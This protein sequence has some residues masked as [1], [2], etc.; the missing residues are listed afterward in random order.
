MRT[1]GGFI[2]GVLTIFYI[3]AQNA[4]SLPSATFCRVCDTHDSDARDDCSQTTGIQSKICTG[5]CIT[6]FTMTSSGLRTQKE[7]TDDATCVSE[8]WLS[9]S[10]RPECQRDNLDRL[11]VGEK[12]SVCCHASR[13]GNIRCS[14]DVYPPA[15]TLV[16]FPEIPRPTLYTP[17]YG[18]KLYQSREKIATSNTSTSQDNV[19]EKETTDTPGGVQIIDVKSDNDTN[20]EFRE[21]M[22]CA[23]CDIDQDHPSCGAST[24]CHG[25]RPLCMTSFYSDGMNNLTQVKRCAAVSECWS[26]WY[27][28]TRLRPDCMGDANND[29]YSWPGTKSG[30][31]HYCCHTPEGESSDWCNKAMWP[32]KPRN[33]VDM[34][35]YQKKLQQIEEKLT[36]DQVAREN[37]TDAQTTE[38]MVIENV[39]KAHPTVQVVTENVTKAVTTEEVV[40][41][42]VTNAQTTEKVGTE[43]ITMAKTTEEVVTEYVKQ[44][45]ITKQA[46]TENATTTYPTEKPELPEYHVPMVCGDCENID[47]GNHSSC[48]QS[49]LCFGSR[50]LCMTSFYSDG[51]MNLRQVK[52]CA[53][54]SECWS[55]W[56]NETRLRPDCM[57]DANNDPYSWPGTK[58]G[59]CH[60]CCHT[61]EG[62]SS[63]WCNKAMW[64]TKPRNLLD[65]PEYEANMPFRE[66]DSKENHTIQETTIDLV[67]TQQVTGVTS[68]I[69]SNFVKFEIIEKFREPMVC[70]ACDIDQDHP[71]CGASTEC[72][73]ARPLCMTS[74]YSDGRNNLTQVK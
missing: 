43:N 31:C 24:E 7:C 47:Q 29:P 54:V 64:P 70:A 26:L 42:K 33:L 68:N 6:R 52:R 48:G 8:W 4:V 44:A 66:V 49:T 72:H 20:T 18:E 67:P 58:S 74:F 21:P 63:D 13:N 34:E 53:A 41:E 73:G 30:E 55:L 59:E 2:L 12:C 3:T 40:R 16:L 50:P 56:Y 17:S 27:N 23:A 36:S 11:H 51:Q 22:V 39:T 61:P 5:A 19:V 9:S 35:E 15:S 60:Y 46:L 69:P 65:M 10:I 25:A 37:I 57:G 71:S 38:Q 1:P 62:E 28:E 32:T 14:D 45:Q